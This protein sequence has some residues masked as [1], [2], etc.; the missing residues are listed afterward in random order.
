MKR[1]IITILLALATMLSCKQQDNYTFN[2]DLSNFVG[3]LVENVTDIDSVIIINDANY[4]AGIEQKSTIKD[5]KFFF[6]G[7]VNKPQY[8]ELKIPF[9]NGEKTDTASL[10]FI[11]EAG[12]L[13]YAEGSV[14]GS[15]MTETFVKKRGEIWQLCEEGKND[16]AQSLYLELIEQHRD[17]AIG[18]ALLSI[19]LPPNWITMTTERKLIE[20]LGDEIKS[21]FRIQ[22]KLEHLKSYHPSD[23]G[24]MFLDFAVEY[25]GKS[26]CLSDYVGRGQY[27]LVDFWASWCGP[28][29]QEIPN[30]I[31]A[32]G[33]YKNKG[34]AVLG[35][36]VSDKPENTMQAIKELSIPYPQIINS[37]KI[38]TD[39][40]GIE[41]IPEIILFAPDGRILKRGLRGNE[42]DIILKEIFGE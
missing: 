4:K 16:E 9:F 30:L 38:A 35:V 8:S 23:E 33:K 39:L 31:A 32:Y 28:C 11:L 36:A 5:G 25:D 19:M 2:G 17:D 10:Q 29:L 3:I 13:V 20:S 37:Q 26:T 14:K 21:D 42:I 22:K 41:G 1:Q 15:P 27:V 12:D 34:L 24:D 6:T 7:Y 40:Y 18:V